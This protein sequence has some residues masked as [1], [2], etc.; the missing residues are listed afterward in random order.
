MSESFTEEEVAEAVKDLGYGHPQEED[1]QNIYAYFKKV[2][3]MGDN[4]KTSNLLD[5]EIGSAKLP[6]RT[7]QEIALYCRMMGMK[8]FANYFEKEA[9][10]ILGTSLSRDGF[11]NK[12]A[13]T[14]KRETDIKA[15]KSVG[16]NK[17]WFKK[18]NPEQQF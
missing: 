12:L 11:L 9:Q 7:H 5:E 17:G 14:Q 13:V 2:I 1:K 10:I 15:R 8:G 3:S 16:V 18:K 6:V 4:A